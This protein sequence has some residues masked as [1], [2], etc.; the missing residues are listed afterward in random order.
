MKWKLYPISEF[1][2]HQHE[3]ERLNQNTTASPLLSLGFVMPLIETFSSGKEVLACCEI[4]GEVQAMAILIQKSRW[5]WT[6][7]QPSQAPL[8]MWISKAGNDWLQCLSELMKV[9]PGFPL[10]LGVTQQD[11][12]LISRPLDDGKLRTLDYIQTASITIEGNFEDYWRARGKNLRQNIKK[13][14]NKLEKNHLDTFLQVSINPDEVSRVIID[15]GKIESAGW[16]AKYGTAIHPA[17]DQGKFYQA[18][19]EAFCSQGKGRIY[20]YWY[21]DQIVA[22]DLCIEDNASIIILKTTYDEKLGDTTSPAL[23]MREEEFRQLF[24]EKKLEKIEFYGKLMDWHTKWSKEI[25]T[26]YHV[27]YFRWTIL[28]FLRHF[29]RTVTTVFRKIK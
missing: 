13:Q 23:L 18:M 8:G 5:V 27:N 6:T 3:W 28:L 22:M 17:N 14:R 2:D 10:V 19:L 21:N 26:M 24:D 15:Y 9:L 7:F 29:I 25:R 20:R 12:D 4:E 11:P 16:K 1:R